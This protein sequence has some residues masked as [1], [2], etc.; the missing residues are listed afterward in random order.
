MTVVFIIAAVSFVVGFPFLAVSVI[1]EDGFSGAGGRVRRLDTAGNRREAVTV[2]DGSG[3]DGIESAR[4][5]MGSR[6]GRGRRA[7]IASRR[8]NTRRAI[9]SN[10]G[11]DGLC[12]E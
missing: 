11:I 6:G 10:A 4:S 12:S 2:A 3:H 9:T 5:S 7:G 8:L 1:V